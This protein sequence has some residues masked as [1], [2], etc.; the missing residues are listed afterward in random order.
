MIAWPLALLLLPPLLWWARVAVIARRFGGA[1][2]PGP[3][4]WPWAL[5]SLVPALRE[6]PLVFYRRCVQAAGD[7]V[8]VWFGTRPHVVVGRPESAL[9]ALTDRASFV[10]E[11]APTVHL[12]GE[13]LL[14]LEGDTWRERRSGFNPAFR[15]ESI[16]TM[17]AAVQVEARALV[18]TWE[19]YDQPFHPSHDLGWTMLRILGAA[20]FEV[21][22]DRERHGG[23]LL[24]RALIV[25]SGGSVR[26]HFLPAWMRRNDTAE[27][28]ARAWMDGLGR[29][30]LDTGGDNP[31]NKALRAL[32][33]DVALDEVRTF[34]VAGHE[35]SATALT[36]TLA[37]LAEHPEVQARARAELRSVGPITAL[38]DLERI[39]YTTWAL[40]RP[41][42]SIRPCPSASPSR[43]GPSCSTGAR[44]PRAPSS[45]SR[46]G[47]CTAIR[48]PGPIPTPSG[49]NVSRLLPFPARISRSSSVPT[50]ASANVSR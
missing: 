26:R 20:L 32:P 24:R 34:L 19:A 25:L 38:S 17:L 21:E 40:Q 8:L 39:P 7:D 35:T 28:E 30:V 31:F 14:R 3:T 49:P 9:A 2:F 45:M 46:R 6:G 13:G 41:F 43:R 1:R 15:R 36:W 22:F 50:S 18:R 37:L 10:R 27:R 29:H 44:Y 23:R 5:G 47:S 12:F 16:E 11:V 48:D 4:A 42:A 33:T